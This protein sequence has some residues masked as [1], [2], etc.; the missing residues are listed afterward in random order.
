MM[1]VWIHAAYVIPEVA[2]KVGAPYFGGA[3]VD[4]FFLISGFIILVTTSRNDV[5]PRRFFTLRI[6]RVVPLYW[7]ATLGMAA[8]GLW[9]P[10]PLS[11][12]SVSPAEAITKSLLFL[13]F[14][15]DGA[16]GGMWPVLMNGWTLNYE[17]FFYALFALSLGLPRYARLAAL[18][19]ALGSLVIVGRA[20]GPFEGTWPSF[21]TNPFLLEFIVGMILAR[22]WLRSGWRMGFLQS[23]LLIVFGF[24]CLGP[25]H[26]RLI[27]MAGGFLIV[28]GCLNPR[29]GQY[30]NRVLLY[31]GNASYSI[32][33]S[34][35]FVLEALAWCWARAFP[36]VTWAA[37]LIFIATAVLLC[38]ALGCL[39][40]RFIEE[41]L[42]SWLRKC[43]QHRD[44][45]SAAANRRN[46]SELLTSSK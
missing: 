10:A 42:T 46:V 9:G 19:L 11:F 7:I 33:L 44:S 24:S 12:R 35:Q 14:S 36:L 38:A 26:S 15:W 17:M 29:I 21:Y 5:S 16:S 28:G 18:T 20:F 23:I 27:N 37:S 30:H 13:P 41:P 25:L 6:I 39:C 8:W 4:L 34:H 1:V 43:A 40:F 32:Y 31:L 2:A 45:A 22:E 3:G